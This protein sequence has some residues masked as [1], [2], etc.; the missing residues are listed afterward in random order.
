M[1]KTLFVKDIK[2]KDAVV[3]PFLVKFSAVAVGKSGKP[4]MNL[5]LM[6]KSG[7]IEGRIWE[8]VPQYVGQ[9]VRDAFV[10]I[11][12]RC[13]TY[14][15]RRQLVVNRVQILREDEVDVKDY[16]VESDLNPEALYSKLLGFV[17]S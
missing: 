11:E 7:E 17:D 14:Q 9:V 10:A 1:K 2:E 15:N 16:V 13:Q 8:D 12:G 6:D 5:V 3:S 4:Y